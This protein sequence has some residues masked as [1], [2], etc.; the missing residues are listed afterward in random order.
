MTDPSQRADFEIAAREPSLWLGHA[1]RLLR[2]ADAVHQ[3]FAHVYA[4]PYA[5][6]DAPDDDLFLCG[7]YLLL[8]G[9]A[10]ENMLKAVLLQ[11]RPELV[12]DGQLTKAGFG[13]GGGHNLSA[14]A[15]EFSPALADRYADLLARLQAHVVWGGRYPVPLKAEHFTTQ[16]RAGGPTNPRTFWT[17]DPAEI[18][19]LAEELEA[20]VSRNSGALAPASGA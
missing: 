8:A 17:S 19:S 4:D 16:P 2:A 10:I 11:R 5:Q 14:M 15:R 20:A 9:M 1:R 6:R 18:Q 13:G 7:P 12:R 3:E